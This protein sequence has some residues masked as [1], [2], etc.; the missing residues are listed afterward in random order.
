MRCTYLSPLAHPLNKSRTA[1]P[2]SPPLHLHFDQ[3]ESFL[4]TK[5]ELCTRL[6]Y[7]N[8]EQTWRPNDGVVVVKTWMP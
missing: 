3:L 6:G 2:Q 7:E 5:G 4:V 1:H 8:K